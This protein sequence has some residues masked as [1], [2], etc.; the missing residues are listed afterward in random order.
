[1][2]IQDNDRNSLFSNGLRLNK[3]NPH[4]GKAQSVKQWGGGYD[5]LSIAESN[6]FLEDSDE[7]GDC[8]N[9]N[10]N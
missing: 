8:M 9:S 4:D 6:P 5:T 7:D 3:G 1:M 2:I 10:L